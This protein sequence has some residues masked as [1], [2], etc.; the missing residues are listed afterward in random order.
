MLEKD[1]K[2]RALVVAVCFDPIFSY[3]R[4]SRDRDILDNAL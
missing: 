2:Y 1:C 3:K 4:E